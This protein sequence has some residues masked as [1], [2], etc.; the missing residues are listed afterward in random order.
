MTFSDRQ[1]AGRQL[2]RALAA[3][4]D[5]DVVVLGLPRGGVVVAAE[6][7]QALDAPLDVIVVRKLGLPGHAELAMGAVGEDDVRVVNDEVIGA[8]QVSTAALGSVEDAER[9]RLR[10][11][12]SRL[13]AQHPRVQL[14][15]RVAVVVDDGIATGATAAVACQVARAHGAREVVLAVPVTLP[16]SVRHVREVADSVVSLQQPD[17][18]AVGQSYADFGEVADAEVTDLLAAS[19]ERSGRH[20]PEGDTP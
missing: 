13:R 7:A 4:R 18:F 2:A 10:E 5:Q 16:G 19:R 6:V 12:A 3:Y 20:G 11:R 1:D 17:T 15:G 14:D 9:E 8:H